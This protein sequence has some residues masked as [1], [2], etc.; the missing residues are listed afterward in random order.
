MPLPIPNLYPAFNTVRLSHVEFIVTDL[1]ASRAF[2]VDTLGLQVTDEDSVR[3][4]RSA[5]P[6]AARISGRT[7]HGPIGRNSNSTAVSRRISSTP[8][9]VRLRRPIN[10]NGQAA[11]AM[12]GRSE[13][14]IGK[15]DSPHLHP[16]RR[17]LAPVS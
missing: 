14:L 12:P 9:S 6:A 5:K 16:N 10:R 8:M 7:P 17:R 1:V 15:F 4:K 2:Y 3:G 13:R 11:K